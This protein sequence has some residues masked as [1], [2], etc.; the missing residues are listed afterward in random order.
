LE[1]ATIGPTINLEANA[2][3]QGGT[4]SGNRADWWDRDS[5]LSKAPVIRTL[6]SLSEKIMEHVQKSDE[7]P[8]GPRGMDERTFNELVLRDLQGDEEENRIML[9]IKEQTEFFTSDKT[10]LSA[11]AAVYIKQD[12][13]ELIMELATDLNPELMDTDEAGGFNL[14]AAIGF[15]EDSDSEDE[16]QAKMPHVGSKSSLADAQ[17]QVNEGINLRRSRYD[18]ADERNALSGL[19][20]AVF[21]RMTLTHATTTEFLHHFWTLFLSGD[22]DKAGELAKLVETL[23]RALDRIN[24]VAADADQERNDTINS[25]KQEIRAIWEK[26]GK[27]LPFK[28]DSIGGGAKVVREMMGPTIVALDRASKEY[29]RALAAEGVDT[30]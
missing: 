1:K 16:D 29:R 28:P 3:N 25:R 23:D 6:N 7:D 24:A 18:D 27:K 9:N 22:P 20:Q 17:N 10:Q 15:D 13:N 11:E 4:K 30:T 12:P 8:T 21:D 2:E 14:T 5:Q 26:T 19:S